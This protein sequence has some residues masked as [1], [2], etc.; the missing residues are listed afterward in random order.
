[1]VYGK[2]GVFDADKLIDLL[3][4]FEEFKVQSRDTDFPSWDFKTCAEQFLCA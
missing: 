2:D 3:G 1:M 4:A